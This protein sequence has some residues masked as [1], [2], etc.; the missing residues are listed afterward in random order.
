MGTSLAVQWLR[1]R[2]SN[3]GSVGL[4]PGWGTRILHAVWR[5]QKKQNKTTERTKPRVN[6]NVNYLP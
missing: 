4:S 1:L 5:G 3:A 6:A 2:V